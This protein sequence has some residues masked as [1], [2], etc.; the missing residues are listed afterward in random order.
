MSANGW[1]VQLSTIGGNCARGFP[2]DVLSVLFLR[3]FRGARSTQF[4]E[5]QIPKIFSRARERVYRDND[6]SGKAATEKSEE[7]F[8]TFDDERLTRESENGQTELAENGNCTIIFEFVAVT[9]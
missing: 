8:R 1:I 3:V 7:T 6:N 4:P 2:E 9:D 5:F